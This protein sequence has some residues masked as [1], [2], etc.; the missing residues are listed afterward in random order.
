MSPASCRYRG[1]PRAA[2]I[3]RSLCSRRA[4]DILPVR[5]AG[6]AI[7]AARGLPVSIITFA[8]QK[9]RQLISAAFRRVSVT[10]ISF[11]IMAHLPFSSPS[12]LEAHKFPRSYPIN[13]GGRQLRRPP[14]AT[15]TLPTNYLPNVAPSFLDFMNVAIKGLAA[16]LG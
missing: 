14:N 7:F 3:R 13:N 5:I 6:R 12:S 2:L 16:R 4:K 11:G 1:G 8:S 10:Q 9:C 15:E